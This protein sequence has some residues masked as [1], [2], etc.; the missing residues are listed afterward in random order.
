MATSINSATS[1]NRD[2]SELQD[3]KSDT[4]RYFRQVGDADDSEEFVLKAA[5]R[6]TVREAAN[7]KSGDRKS[8]VDATKQLNIF[9]FDDNC[10]SELKWY[11][12]E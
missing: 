6:P 4:D 8:E 9:K 5:R 1:I 11:F 10:S 2:A 12:N 7:N 3:P